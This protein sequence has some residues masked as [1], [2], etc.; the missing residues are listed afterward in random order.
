MIQ[1]RIAYLELMAAAILVGS[2]VVAGKLTTLRMPVFL[3]QAGSLTIALLLLVPLMLAR[4][5]GTAKVGRADIPILLLQALLGMF[6]FRVLMLYGLKYATAADIGIATSLTPAA[7]ALLSYILL[8]EKI[9][10]RIIAGITSSV[11][12][13]AFIQ[14]PIWNSH[15]GNSG[16][17]N[18]ALGMILILLAVAGEAM[19]T[20]LRKKTSSRLSSLTGTTYVTLFSW[21]MFLPFAVIEAY[22]YDFSLIG[23]SEAGLIVYYG[24]M[25]TAV[26]YLLWFRGVAKVPAS[27]AA[28]YTGCIPIS[29]LLLSYWILHEP[30]SMVHLG[31]ACFV[32]A[33]IIL[34]SGRRRA[35][36]AGDYAK[37]SA[38]EPVKAI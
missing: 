23:V 25:V 13:V 27:T 7:V 22:E 33:G 28:V 15:E 30:V 3:S 9:T 5:D 36:A 11:A 35:D 10:R 32:M 18:S 31:G 1:R 24:V 34:I 38:S 20:V 6:L 21:I 14:A 19:L 8:K 37:K 16:S 17:E 26:A 2:S 4:R 12:G 29:T